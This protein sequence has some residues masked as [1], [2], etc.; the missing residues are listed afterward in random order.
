MTAHNLRQAAVE[1][2]VSAGNLRSQPWIEAFRHIPRHNFLPR[3]FR[4]SPDQSGWEPV[5]VSDPDAL[6]MIYRDATW[7]T[8]L[9]NDPDRWQVAYDS[10][11]PAQGVPTSSSTAPGLMALMLEELDVHDGDRVLEIGTGTGYNAALLCHRLGAD[12]VTTVE[13]DQAVAEAAQAGLDACGY[14]PAVV[15]ADGATVYPAG[16]LFN[17]LIATCSAPAVPTAWIKQV[18]P[19]G[20]ILTSLF[21]DLGGGPL[22]LLRVGAGG[23]AEGRFLPSYG[24]FMPVRTSPPADALQRLNV[25]LDEDEGESRPTTLTS[26]LLDT[27]HFGM[28]L[29]LLMPGVSTIG[30]VPATGPQRWLLAEDGSWAR[31][32][33]NA[34]TVTQH[35]PSLLWDRVEKAYAA[36]QAAGGPARDRY[37]LTVTPDRQW[38]WLDEPGREINSR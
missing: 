32:E 14:R 9:D 2:L 16:D 1:R 31:L 34:G 21:R 18:H 20:L 15:V 25:A 37:G 6:E 29:A 36:W 7:V 19:G 3:F 38:V 23:S 8:Q 12:M 30:F 26:D 17:R 28:V 11:K 24:G 22:A 5:S 35:G 4:Q 13:V 33:E 10:G 27:P